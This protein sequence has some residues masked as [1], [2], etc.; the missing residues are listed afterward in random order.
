M[1]APKLISLSAAVLGVAIVVL[2]FVLVPERLATSPSAVITLVVLAASVVLVRLPAVLVTREARTDAGSLA[3]LGPAATLGI[4]VIVLAALGFVAALL[5]ATR[6]GIAADVIAV[7]VL[8]SGSLFLRAAMDKVQAVSDAYSGPSKLAGWRS[9][10]A[11]AAANA[12]S[13][14]HRAKLAAL[15]EQARYAASDIPGGCPQDGPLEAVVAALNAAAT[16]DDEN[17]F[18]EGV[19]DFENLMAQRELTL[20]AARSRA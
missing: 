20:K 8:V 14:P 12:V 15:E 18:A 1:N 7:A 11:V 13:V 10:L 17:A 3:V 6:L 5:G 19:R 9:G 16:S 2:G 4:W